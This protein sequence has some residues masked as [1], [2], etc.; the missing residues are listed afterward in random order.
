M[1]RSVENGFQFPKG[2]GVT[3]HGH[4]LVCDSGNHRVQEFNMLDGF[5]FVREF[6]THGTGEGQFSTPL[7]VAV[8]RS[9]EILVSDASNRVSVFDKEGQFLR[10]FGLK[11]RKDGSLNYPVNMAVN[12][13]D[14]LFVCDQGNN[15]VQVLSASDGTF[16]HKWGASKKKKGAEEEEPPAEEAEEGAE[17]P[18]ED[19]GML[20]PAAVAVNS[21]G[22]VVV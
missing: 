20:R 10:S 18:P 7:G 5:S 8:N 3:D 19:P 4:I 15:R 16:L 17:K 13:E 14:A 9:G 11:G 1:G 2:I 12:D 21:H 22:L 6:G